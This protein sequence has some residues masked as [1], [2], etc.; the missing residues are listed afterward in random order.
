MINNSPK[1]EIE[2]KKIQD[3][4]PETKSSLEDRLNLIN[5]SYKK[6]RF[7]DEKNDAYLKVIL[8]S[9]P[10]KNLISYDAVINQHRKPVYT[11]T[12]LAGAVDET[13]RKAIFDEQK[14]HLRGDRPGVRNFLITI[15]KAYLT[16]EGDPAKV[17]VS[18]EIARIPQ[19]KE[20]GTDADKY[21]LASVI[22]SVEKMEP[23]SEN[24]RLLEVSD[25]IWGYK[26]RNGFDDLNTFTFSVPE[27]DVLPHGKNLSVYFEAYHL[28][29]NAE[30][31]HSYRME[32]TIKRKKRRKFIDTGIKLTLNLN[33]ASEIGKEEIE[34]KTADLEPG[35]YRA[36]FRF[37][38]PNSPAIIKE[39]YIDFEV[40]E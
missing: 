23:L 2:L 36:E 8:F 13:G 24:R 26:D 5:Q 40:Q 30:N 35:N 28:K 7:L 6:Y 29:P 11:L 18:S 1:A 32:Y 17:L 15:P 22:D 27:D 39:R 25:I 16:Q 10:Y 9:T 14:I 34:I 20:L 3:R 37:S 33:A 31:L 19:L 21:I 38:D 4:A 12:A